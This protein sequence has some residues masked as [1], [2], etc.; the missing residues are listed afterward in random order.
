ARL[1]LPSF[2]AKLCRFVCGNHMRFHRLSEMRKA[3]KFD[4]VFDIYKQS[5]HKPE[6]FLIACLADRYCNR[7]DDEWQKDFKDAF[8][9]ISAVY[10][11]ASAIRLA[12]AEITAIP[13]E[14]RADALRQKRLKRIENLL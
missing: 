10:D 14:K 5:E 7:D 4:F 2:T 8:D 9:L 3:T 13:P 11:N 12:K 6:I 1:K